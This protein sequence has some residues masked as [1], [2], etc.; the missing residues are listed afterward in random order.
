MKKNQDKNQQSYDIFI[1]NSHSPA[2]AKLMISLNV[3]VLNFWLRKYQ[4]KKSADVLEVGPGKGYFFKA[5]E[6][7]GWQGSYTALDRNSLILKN[8]GIKKVIISEL[9]KIETK[10]K[11]DLVHC[12]YVL[13]HLSSYQEVYKTLVN[14]KQVLTTDGYLLLSVPDFMGQKT[15]F[16]NID[17]SH[18]YPTTKRNMVMALIDAGFQE[19]NIE[20]FEIN[21]LLTL[22]HFDSKVAYLLIN[23]LMFFYSYRFFHF[24]Q[25]LF[26]RKNVYS[27]NN[28]FYRVYCLCKEPNLMIV[29]KK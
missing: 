14:F 27:L 13:E 12:A 10:E 8:L 26:M 19:E 9:P 25:Y 6:Q 5:L 17:Y 23:W 24:W 1:K 29:V 7:I 18:T 3:N 11:F 16:W 20:I 4:G 28:F 22:P 21:G 2:I 15:E